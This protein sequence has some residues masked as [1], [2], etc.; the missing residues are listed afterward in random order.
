M[1]GCV[2]RVGTVTAVDAKKLCAR[3]RFDDL[4]DIENQ[5]MISDWLQVLQRPGTQLD[6]TVD[7]GHDHN[8]TVND[9][10]S[11]G[12]SGSVDAAPD[13]SH[14]ESVTSTW[15]PRVNDQVLVLYEGVSNG[16]GFI[17][18]GVRPWR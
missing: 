13:H 15:M 3:V 12:G 17:L 16:R 14:I 10:Y 11:G 8:I 7:G 4:R 5:P 2:L 18:G 6:I 9:T 1:D